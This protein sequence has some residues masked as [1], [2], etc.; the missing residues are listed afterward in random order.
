MDDLHRFGLRAGQDL[1]LR[2][3]QQRQ[4]PSNVWRY[5][6]APSEG[7]CD[8]TESFTLSPTFGLRLYWALWGWSR[9][10][11]NRKGMRT[12]LERIRDEVQAAPAA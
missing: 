9:G 2:G 8:V 10:K 1:R 5:D 7:G 12:T 4:A 11:V 3:G 6:I